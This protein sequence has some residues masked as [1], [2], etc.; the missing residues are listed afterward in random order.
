MVCLVDGH[1]KSEREEIHISVI[2][3]RLIDLPVGV[4]P[5]KIEARMEERMP[6]KVG[7]PAPDFDIPGVVG[8]VKVRVKLSEYR[9]KNLVL[10]F[11]ALDWTPT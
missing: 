7:D 11:Y 3:F 1:K 8:N 2:S 9:G 10:A 6:L 4:S 5:S